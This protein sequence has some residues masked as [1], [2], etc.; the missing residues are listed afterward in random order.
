VLLTGGSAFGLAAADGVMRF[1]EERGHGRAHPR[2]RRCPIVVGFGLFDLAVGSIPP[3]GPGP[4]R[5]TRPARPP[6]PGPVPWPHRR[7]QRA[8]PV[9]CPQAPPA[10][11]V[12][13]DRPGDALPGATGAEPGIGPRPESGAPARGTRR[14]GRQRLGRRD[15]RGTVVPSEGPVRWLCRLCGWPASRPDRGPSGRGV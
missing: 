13:A 9:G 2:R 12:A 10:P 11:G 15:G 4:S 8:P 6:P 14:P 7:R 1:C 3:C 5:A